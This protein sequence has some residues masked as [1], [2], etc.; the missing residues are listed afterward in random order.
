MDGQGDDAG[1]NGP[2][3]WNWLLMTKELQLV[4]PDLAG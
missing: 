1:P 2:G 4:V 3:L